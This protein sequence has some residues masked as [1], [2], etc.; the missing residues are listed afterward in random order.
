MADTDIKENRDGDDAA[1]CDQVQGGS[2]RLNGLRAKS[3]CAKLVCAVALFMC[4]NTSPGLPADSVVQST[5]PFVTAV[6]QAARGF[7]PLV[8]LATAFVALW[9]IYK[10]QTTYAALLGSLPPQFQDGSNSRFAF[11]EWVLR[12]STPLPLQSDYVKSQAGFCLV[13]LG[14]AMLCLLSGKTEIGAM[15]LA[16]LAAFSA[17]TIKSWK[18][19][20]ANKTRFASRK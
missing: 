17:L 11:P 5:T 4:A 10:Y 8:A 6:T 15:V 3:G 16:M 9:S 14:I 2:M 7:I 1:A 19:F 13:T 20:R 18:L 12:P